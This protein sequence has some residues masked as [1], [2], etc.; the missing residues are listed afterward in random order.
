MIDEDRTD[1]DSYLEVYLANPPKLLTFAPHY[2]RRFLAFCTPRLEK[3]Y[4]KNCITSVLSFNA[5]S[6][7]VSL[8]GIFAPALVCKHFVI[9]Q[10]LVVIPILA[11]LAASQRF[12]ALGAYYREFNVL[13]IVLAYIG[14]TYIDRGLPGDVS[15]Y[16]AFAFV[17]LPIKVNVLTIV[18]YRSAL[19]LAVFYAPA[20]VLNCVTRPA[21]PPAAQIFMI[22]TFLMTTHATL[23]ARYRIEQAERVNYLTFLRENLR[24]ADIREKNAELA[25]QSRTDALTG[26]SNRRDFDERF[27]AAIDEVGRTQQPLAVLILDID[28]FK[29]YND[30]L[31]HPEGDKCIFAVAQAVARSVGSEPNFASRIGGEEF[32]VVIPGAGAEAATEAARNIRAAV[33][34]LRIPHP[35]LG[36]RRIVSV[37]LGAACLNPACLEA[38][39]ALLGRPDA[40]LYRAKRAGRDRAEFD[41]KL[42]SA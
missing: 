6:F 10:S 16:L 35:A 11:I 27:A 30:S 29:M 25:H 31:G 2:E 3:E 33:E 22:S 20:F 34:A 8:S 37:S 19:G 12:S 21:F 42:I 9:I 4:F 24:N 14:M 28:K 36:E 15:I 32:A 7:I 13:N 41:F 17:Y 39:G 5:I 1:V 18:P 23:I 38:P 26:L 40:A